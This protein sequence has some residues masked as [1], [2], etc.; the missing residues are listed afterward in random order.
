MTMVPALPRGLYLLTR[1]TSDTD[2][3]LRIVGAALD[4]GA[5]A[6]QYRDKSSDLIR[7]LAQ[8]HALVTLCG[9]RGVPLIVND[10]VALA[11]QAGAAGVHLGEHDGAI[12]DARSRLG[13]QA[14][15]GVS[16]YDDP[17]RAARLASEGASYL[18]FGSFFDSPTKPAARRAHPGLLHDALRH[19]LPLVAIG[20][21]T[22]S[23]CGP[24]L[25]A[26]ASLLAVISEVFDAADPRAAAAAIASRFAAT[27]TAPE[28]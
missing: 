11:A 12:A 14:I 5:V 17:A 7:R 28:S 27:P 25:A 6:V 10:D 22:A 2:A 4:G 26:G 3:L 20:G 23:N 1:E 21:I 19:G 13:T 24:A 16:C 15:I 18:A 8:A 9:A